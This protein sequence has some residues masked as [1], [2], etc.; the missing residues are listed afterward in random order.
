MRILSGGVWWDAP[1]EPIRVT[2]T[3][4]QKRI[5]A[6]VVLLRPDGTSKVPRLSTILACW[7]GPGS[8]GGV[9]ES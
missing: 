8:G 4:R 1:S 3:I 7:N 2:A 9:G 5:R 6:L